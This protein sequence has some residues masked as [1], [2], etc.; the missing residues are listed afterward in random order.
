MISGKELSIPKVPLLEDKN[1][2]RYLK[3][4]VSAL[5]QNRIFRAEGIL[6]L[7]VSTHSASI[8]NIKA[9][10][11]SPI[12]SVDTSGGSVELRGFSDGLNGQTVFVVKPSSSNSIIVKHNHVDATQK[13]LT[14]S[15]ADVTLSSYEGCILV[16]NGTSWRL[17]SYT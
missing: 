7:D 10:S 17:C 9:D 13:I 6:V 16:C 5:E 1:T 4:L 12:L 15:S 8:N 11:I 2:E 14:P 3:Q